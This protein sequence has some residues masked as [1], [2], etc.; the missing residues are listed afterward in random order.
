[1][2][3]QTAEDTLPRHSTLPVHRCVPVMLPSWSLSVWNS[4]EIF[5]DPFTDFLGFF[6]PRSFGLR[7]Y[8]GLQ[9]VGTDP[10]W[11]MRVAAAL[12]VAQQLWL[13]WHGKTNYSSMTY[14]IDPW[15]FSLGAVLTFLTGL[16]VVPALAWYGFALYLWSGMP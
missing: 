5:G 4:G 9:V 6:N 10:P 7:T 11:I 14:A 2:Q 1:M 15:K 8:Y 13:A 3:P 12:L 16:V